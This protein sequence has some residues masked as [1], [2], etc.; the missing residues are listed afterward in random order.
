VSDGASVVWQ[1]TPAPGPAL[2]VWTGILAI[3]L[4]LFAILYSYMV[5]TG[6]CVDLILQEDCTRPRRKGPEVVFIVLTVMALAAL[7]V[8]IRTA[9]GFPYQRYTVTATEVRLQTGWPLTSTKVQPLAYVSVERRGDSLRFTG[10][11]EKPICFDH[12]SQGEADRLI[13]MIHSLKAAQSADIPK[14]GS[15]DR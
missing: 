13:E 15:N 1:G 3:N 12:L 11:G 9:L 14:D 10:I 2:L 8:I 4:G 5:L 6:T 7:A